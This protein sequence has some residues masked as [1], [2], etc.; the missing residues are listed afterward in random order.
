MTPEPNNLAFVQEI[1]NARR[2]KINPLEEIVVTVPSEP[3]FSMA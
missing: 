1:E 3:D 2:F